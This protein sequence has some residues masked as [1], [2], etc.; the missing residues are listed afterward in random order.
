MTTRST[1]FQTGCSA[2]GSRY[3]K[4]TPR[5]ALHLQTVETAKLGPLARKVFGFAPRASKKE[6]SQ[7]EWLQIENEHDLSGS[8]TVT[9]IG[10]N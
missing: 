10:W 6:R 9:H 3:N 8:K 7:Y 5:L 2:G 1:M 4:R